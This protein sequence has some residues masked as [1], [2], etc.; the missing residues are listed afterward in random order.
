MSEHDYPLTGT[1]P[2]L[3]TL[4]RERVSKLPCRLGLRA[5]RSHSWDQSLK[6][7]TSNSQGQGCR[8]WHMPN[9]LLLLFSLFSGPKKNIKTLYITWSAIVMD[10]RSSPIILNH[11]RSSFFYYQNWCAVVGQ[12]L[13]PDIIYQAV[14]EKKKI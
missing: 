7:K 9:Y 12:C 10:N 13:W 1:L 11:H 4:Q 2:L 6:A 3:N 14:L 8:P 5:L